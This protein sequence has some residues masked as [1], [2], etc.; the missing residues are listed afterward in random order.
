M[1]SETGWGYEN[2]WIG[3]IYHQQRFAPISVA[4]RTMW[5]FS[6]CRLK[7]KPILQKNELFLLKLLYFVDGG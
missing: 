1:L 6:Q 7:I 4:D 3:Q 5:S 2:V